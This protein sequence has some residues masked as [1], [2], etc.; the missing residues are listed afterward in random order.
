M[1]RMLS[2]LLAMLALAASMPGCAVMERV[3]PEPPGEDPYGTATYYNGYLGLSVTVPDGWNEEEV[4]ARNL[5][6]NPEDSRD[7]SSLD[8]YD[9]GDG[10][11]A[12]ELMSIQNAGDSTLDDHAELMLY[13]DYYPQTDEDEY[14]GWMPDFIEEQT[15]GEYTYVLED[16]G[17]RSVNGR[18]Y[19]RFLAKVSFWNDT[20]PYYEEYYITMVNGMFFVA[21]I[22]YW[23][24]SEQ[25]KAA[26]YDAL[27]NAFSLGS[28]YGSGRGY[29]EGLRNPAQQV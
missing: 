24:G 18:L 27:E 17:E 8:M 14:L 6:G 16:V 13:A 15:D 3:Q 1:L 25:S 20:E 2:A 12:I 19:T 11:Y 28:D 26:A 21:Y 7:L 4:N 5:T 23:S 10:G 9:Y 29:G 22:N